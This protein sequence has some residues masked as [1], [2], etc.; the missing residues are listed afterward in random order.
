MFEICADAKIQPWAMR[1]EFT[2]E[3]SESG[4]ITDV[5]LD[6]TT[7]RIVQFEPQHNMNFRLPQNTNSQEWRDYKKTTLVQ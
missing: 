6:K 3:I 2:R 5:K 1:K 4:E 7:Q